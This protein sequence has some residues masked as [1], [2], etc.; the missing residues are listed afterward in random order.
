[1]RQKVRSTRFRAAFPVRHYARPLGGVATRLGFALGIILVVAAPPVG[2]GAQGPRAHYVTAAAPSGGDGTEARPWTLEA[3][4]AQPR[5]VKPGDTIWVKGGLYEKRS[6]D[7]WAPKLT[8]TPESSITLRAA[9][10]ERVQCTGMWKIY[11]ADAWYWGLE[12]TYL[13]TESRISTQAGSDPTDQPARGL[14]I[15]YGDRV[16]IINPVVHDLNEGID[17]F[18]TNQA[19]DSSVYGAVIFN[20]GWQGSDRGNGS[21]MYIQSDSGTKWVTDVISFNNFS[22]GMKG[23]GRAGAVKG[24]V[25]DGVMSF[26]AGAYAAERPGAGA[27]VQN[28]LV[29]TSNVPADGI[30]VKDSA[31]Y[32]PPG[33]D[34][35]NLMFGNNSARGLGLKVTGNYVAGGDG[36]GINRYATAEVTGNTVYG[37]Q[38]DPGVQN[39]ALVG[40]QYDGEVPPPSPAYTW[41]R[42]SYF[43]GILPWKE[44]GRRYSFSAN[45]NRAWTG[46]HFLRPPG[47]RETTKYDANSTYTVGRPTGTKVIVRPNRHEPG[48]AHIAV[49]NWGGA[50]TVPV[51]AS[52]SLAVGD[53]YEVLDVQNYFGAPVLAGTYDGKPLVLPMNLTTVARA[54]GMTWE[55]KHTAPEFAVFVLRRVRAAAAAASFRFLVNV[56]VGSDGMP[57]LDAAPLPDPEP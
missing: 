37:R 57:K 29:T 3:A 40:V 6:P 15:V 26:S 36:I 38:S 43:D 45:G 23:F 9:P 22:T 34:A 55:P 18:G 7:S 41:D 28:L 12:H 42:N 19:L 52:G 30:V 13:G 27:R 5:T 56:T 53:R 49:Y 46:G 54:T 31:F 50:A 11:G 2:L 20:N 21:G 17:F 14:V 48:R 39:S 24:I 32:H 44:D 16:K 10:G 8:G 33:A 51:D 1:M 4:L 35:M 47:W 25:F